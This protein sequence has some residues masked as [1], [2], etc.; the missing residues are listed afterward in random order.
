MYY[1]AVGVSVLMLLCV[2]T[3]ATLEADR[4]L[5]SGLIAMITLV[6]PAAEY[7]PANAGHLLD[8]RVKVGAKPADLDAARS[9]TPTAG[10]PE[11][12]EL[13][14]NHSRI[15]LYHPRDISS[16]RLYWP[17]S[18]GTEFLYYKTCGYIIQ[19]SGYIGHFER[20]E[21]EHLRA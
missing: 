11:S 13:L 12:N 7:S 1:A 4:I 16:S 10:T 21:R 2:V 18:A 5:K 8:L 15:R 3:A 19:S 6:T 9:Y 20:D 14:S 17:F